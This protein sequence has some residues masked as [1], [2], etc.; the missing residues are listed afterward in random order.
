[1]QACDRSL[2]SGGLIG[3]LTTRDRRHLGAVRS[4]PSRQLEE[5]G[6]ALRSCVFSDNSHLF[7]VSG[8]ATMKDRDE[9]E[10]RER[11]LELADKFAREVATWSSK[12]LRMTYA[13]P[14]AVLRAEERERREQSMRTTRDRE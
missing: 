11:R 14:E 9:Q 6:Q 10:R 5:R 4:P 12:K 2:S 13:Q 8:E 1:L 3:K 7:R